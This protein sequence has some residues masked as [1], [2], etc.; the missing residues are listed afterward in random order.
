MSRAKHHGEDSISGMS[1]S[2]EAGWQ[3]GVVEGAAGW[4]AMFA[5]MLKRRSST[6]DAIDYADAAMR[7]KFGKRFDQECNR[8]AEPGE[9][10][11]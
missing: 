9:Q 1:A 8:R 6:Q 3:T 2:F 11:E 4:R 10:G 5:W 7:R